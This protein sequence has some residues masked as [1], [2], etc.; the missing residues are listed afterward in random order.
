M[1]TGFFKWIW[2]FNALA[3]ALVA[4]LSLSLLGYE[5][6]RN[7]SRSLF[8]NN[9]SNSIT[10]SPPDVVDPEAALQETTE[11]RY[12][13][14]PLTGSRNGI[15]ALPLY[16]EQTEAD[17]GMSY[18]KGSNGNLVNIRIVQSEQQTNH[19]LFTPGERLI[20][21]TNQLI[22]SRSGLPDLD[23]GQQLIV[24]DKDT[25]GDDRLSYEDT[26]TLYLTDVNWSE[27]VKVVDGVRSVL[28]TTPISPTMMDLIYS[29]GTS[30]HIMRVTLPSGAVISE[31]VIKTRD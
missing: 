13:S 19:W 9:T 5:L 17:H 26:R 16:I 18:S 2:R 23:L 24:I 1:E 22:L 30:T 10:L 28:S 15:Y 14:G 11:K 21:N 31:Q 12:F 20:Q 3:I 4:L 25:N 27:P 6:M 29:D 7:L 8:Q